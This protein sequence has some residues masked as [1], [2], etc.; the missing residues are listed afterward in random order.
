[1]DSSTLPGRWGLEGL[2]HQR[3]LRTSE[4]SG[5]EKKAPGDIGSGISLPSRTT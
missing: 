5:V 3:Q 2:A 1:M 4:N